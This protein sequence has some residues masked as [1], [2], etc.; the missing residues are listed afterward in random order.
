[1][2]AIPGVRAVAIASRVPLSG[3]NPQVNVIAE[4]RPLKPGEPVL[5]A[6]N[7]Y[8]TPGYFAAIGTP[9]LRGRG[10][11]PSD[12]ER[13]PR[14]VVVDESLA[15]HFWP[16]EDA[17]GKRLRYQG[18]T[19]SNA[20]MTIVGIVPNVKHNSLDERPDL[21]MYEP[22][23]QRTH[24]M[25]YIVVR[26]TIAPEAIVAQ[27]RRVVAAADPTLPLFGAYTLQRSVNE[28]LGPRRL[29]NAVLGGFAAMALVLAAIGIYG[30][31]ALSVNGRMKEFGIR[32]ALGARAADVRGLVLGHGLVLALVGVGIGLAGA[33]WVTRFLRSLLF[34]VSPVDWVTFG[35]VA[36][37]LSGAALVACYLPA[38]RA[39]RSDPI[40]VLR[41]E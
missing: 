19:S 25:T 3:G 1:V 37:V 39:T 32:I 16:T 24:W 13:A 31:I 7:R 41:A 5:V 33:V 38:R 30:V 2:Q 36:V 27:M 35:A 9:I 20:V 15:H 18:D 11:L 12:D 26:T 22:F 4:G 8:V 23:A 14:V 6:N 29:T 17:L 34:G 28:S 21:Q 40:V 10:L